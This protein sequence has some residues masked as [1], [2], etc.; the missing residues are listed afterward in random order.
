MEIRLNS[1]CP[2][3]LD[4]TLCCGQ[5]FRWNKHDEWWYG[6]VEKNIF[7]IC[8]IRNNL[9]FENA[10]TNQ[11]KKYF[12]LYDKLP[13]I[14]SQIGNDK[15][16][17]HAIALFKGLRILRQNPWECLISYI[18]ATY[19]NIS[20]IRQT[21]FNLC[22]KFG[23][24]VNF[25][26]YNFYTFPTPKTLAKAT[27]N[28]LAECGLG[29]RAEYVAETAKRVYE[30]DFKFE[31]LLK[32]PYEKAREELLSFSGVGLKVADCVLLFSL[33]KFEAF[34]IDVWIKRAILKYYKSHFPKEFILKIS[35]KTLLTSLE[36]ETLNFFG[37]KYFGKYA[38]YAQEYLYHYE[39][40]QSRINLH[41]R[42]KCGKR[43]N[44][45]GNAY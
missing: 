1:S 45:I 30:S 33:E 25:D 22:R 17:R 26:S 43:L 20:A 34:P 38:G 3:N 4:A 18:C 40:T 42:L 44:Q 29:Y 21:L 27:A 24:K 16:I 9:K 32:M 13:E 28:E 11:I 23:D 6:V 10:E 7:K 2:F 15:H 35:H 5:A 41:N 12:G 14:F 36:Y 37:R 39:R 8:Q 31:H 19:K